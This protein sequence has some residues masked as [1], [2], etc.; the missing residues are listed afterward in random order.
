MLRQHIASVISTDRRIVGG[1]FIPVP[2]TRSARG[3]RIDAAWFVR[4]QGS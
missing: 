1:D 2:C 4:H 3:Y